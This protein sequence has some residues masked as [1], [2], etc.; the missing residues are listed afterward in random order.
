MCA[1]GAW[2]LVNACAADAE[3]TVACDASPLIYGTDDRI[4]LRAAPPRF[5]EVAGA[6]VGLVPA[7]NYEDLIDSPGSLAEFSADRVFGLCPEEFGAN[8]PALARCTGVLIAPDIV[9][10]AGH[11]FLPS[12]RCDRYV[13]MTG[14]A[15]NADGDNLDLER[16]EVRRCST[17]S[18]RSEPTH[19]LG[20]SLDYALVR[21]EAPMRAKPATLAHSL[22]W[23]GQ[24][25]VA[26]THPLGLP[27]KLDMGASVL[28][29]IDQPTAGAHFAA[30]IDAFIG[31]SGGAVFDVEGKLVGLLVGGEGDFDYDRDRDCFRSRAIEAAYPSAFEWVMSASVLEERVCDSSPSLSFCNGGNRADD[32]EPRAADLERAAVPCG[33]G[34]AP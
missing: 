22:P 9:L 14:L 10:T 27:L 24:P 15:L 31:S 7:E 6:V 34:D 2:I 18:A 33:G 28:A 12:D 19:E 3:P 5:R 4:E 20:A 25:L 21:L 13:Y 26:A 32:E 29:I 1:A 16:A 8:Q 23:V 30:D 17:I 11:C